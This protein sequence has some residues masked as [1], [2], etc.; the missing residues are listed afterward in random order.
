MCGRFALRNPLIFKKE[1]KEIIL[2]QRFNI[3]PGQ[4]IL[5]INKRPNF[6]KWGFTPYWAE[7][8]FNLINARSDTL[9]KKPSFKNSSRCLIPADGWYEWKNE[10]GMKTPYFL[11]LEDQI[12]YFAGVYGG[13]RGEVG[14]AIVTKEASYNISSIHDRMPFIVDKNQ[15]QDWLQGEEILNLDSSVSEK[16]TFYQVSTHVNNPNQDD[17]Q[18][19]KEEFSK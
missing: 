16:I 14:C 4:K 13:Y 1:F 7:K 3:A 6:I 10:E 15:H 18:C 19:I 2:E 17:E 5:T 11:H 12:F 8:P 9:S